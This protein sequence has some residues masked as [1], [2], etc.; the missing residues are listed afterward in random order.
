VSTAG[1][2][3]PPTAPEILRDFEVVLDERL[4]DERQ[5][6][7][8]SERLVRI[9]FGLAV[10]ALLGTALLAYTVHD[11]R[12]PGITSG[13]VRTG[14]LRLVD[15]AGNVRGRWIVQPGGTTRLSFLDAAGMERMRFTLLESGGQGITLADAQG[16]GRVVLSFEGGEGSRLTLAD[17][18]GRPRTILGLSPRDGSTLLF[19]DEG[20]QPRAALG[21]R[22]DGRATF[23]L[24]Q[25]GQAPDPV[26]NDTT[27]T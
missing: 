13:V 22:D 8:K 14:E 10:L 7:R 23:M 6:R 21:L 11:Q 20:G 26:P 16:E 18:A 3:R 2:G 24:P 25:E 15:G 17:A 5:R 12:G 27:D 9:G 19:A 1:T 4:A